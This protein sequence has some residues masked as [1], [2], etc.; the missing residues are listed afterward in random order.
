[1]TR[2]VT[3]SP[4]LGKIQ[5]PPSDIMT[6]LTDINV[7]RAFPVGSKHIPVRVMLVKPR[8]VPPMISF[9]VQPDTRFYY[10]DE[11]L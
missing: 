4:T 5:R 1:M 11:A 9:N 7:C 10:N 8:N 6:D 3:H 2:R